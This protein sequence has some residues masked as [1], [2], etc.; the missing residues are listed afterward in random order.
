[1]PDD[2][3]P[4]G[5]LPNERGQE[6]QWEWDHIAELIKSK[7]WLDGEALESVR[8]HSSGFSALVHPGN[9]SDTLDVPPLRI[10]SLNADMWYSSNVYT[11]IDSHNPDRSGMLRWVTDELLHA[12]QKGEKVWI[13]GHVLP[14]WSGTNA[15][16]NPTQLFHAIVDRFSST[17]LAHIFFGHTHEDQSS[18]FYPFHPAVSPTQNSPAPAAGK[19]GSSMPI[20][21]A[22][23]ARN[24]AFMAPSVTP[25]THLNPEFRIYTVD[26]H[27]WVVMDIEQYASR[28]Q[29]VAAGFTPSPVWELLY[30][31]RETYGHF[32]SLQAD[33]SYAGSV[34]LGG[35]DGATWPAHVPLN[36]TFWAALT[37]EMV[38]RPSLVALHTALSSGN[39]TTFE[40]CTDGECLPA[41]ICY[42]RAGDARQGSEC[43]KGYDSVQG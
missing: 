1:M 9:R 3:V 36:G 10:I 40:P 8:K 7:G 4:V 39:S 24:V 37:D 43:I 18:V 17:S 30:S 27:G 11:L 22:R 6:L 34:A 21:T 28:L 12:E 5:T 16:A 13:M 33:G 14:A 41:K 20:D 31:A 35:A 2:F 32:T 25:G 15:W 23:S 42:I 19:N 29:D 38:L 26:P